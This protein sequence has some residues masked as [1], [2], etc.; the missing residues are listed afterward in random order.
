MKLEFSLRLDTTSLEAGHHNAEILL[1]TNN[2]TYRVIVYFRKILRWDII[3]K[4]AAGIGI[5]TGLFMYCIRL[6]LGNNLSA[7]LDD[8]W[9]L[10]YPHEVKGASFFRLISPLDLFTIPEVQLTCSIFGVIVLFAITIAV[11]YRIKGDHKY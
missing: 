9:V 11:A 6:I 4:L 10:S 8:G 2:G 5:P 3:T 7:G 1:E